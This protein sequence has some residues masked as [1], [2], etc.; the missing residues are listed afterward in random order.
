MNIKSAFIQSVIEQVKE[1][2]SAIIQ[3]VKALSA[4]V[5]VMAAS[6]AMVAII[7]QSL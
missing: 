3:N 6:A 5:K 7:N 2:E 1:S 4:S